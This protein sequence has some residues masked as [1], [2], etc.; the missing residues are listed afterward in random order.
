[1]LDLTQPNGMFEARDFLIRDGDTV[2][3]TEAPY[4]QWNK[5]LAALTGAT[6]AAANLT[7]TADSLSRQ[8]RLRIRPC[9]SSAIRNPK[10]PWSS[11]GGFSIRTCRFLRNRR[12]HR[13]LALMGHE[14]RLGLPR[15]GD[16]VAVWGASPTAGRGERAAARRGRAR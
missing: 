5:T 6:G 10:P 14:L 12:L 3:V 15:P 11:P 8:R 16:G 2:Y 1:M 9:P 4:V 7:S 13:I